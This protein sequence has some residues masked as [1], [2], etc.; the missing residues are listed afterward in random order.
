MLT[1]APLPYAVKPGDEVRELFECDFFAGLMPALLA[2]S[3][4]G[5]VLDLGC[6]DG[7]VGR[8]AGPS[9]QRYVGVDLDPGD[10]PGDA[11]RHDL[12]E[13][14]GPVGSKPFDL[15]VG[16]FGVA[17][18]LAPGE[19]ERLLVEIARHARPG[20]IVALEGLGVNSLEWPRLWNT[21]PGAARL[22][23]YRLGAD[24]TVHPWAPHELAA[25]YESAGIRPLRA[26]DRTVQGAPKTG[27]PRYWPGM[28]CIRRAI[29]ALL[30]GERLHAARAALAAPLPPL[31]PGAP[32]TVHSRIAA[33]RRRAVARG[34]CLPQGLARRV[35]SLDGH[36]SGG[37][38]HG[39]LMVGRVS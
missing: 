4:G 29:A 6:A 13:G 33:R 35:W 38:G 3:S 1:E 5:A 16:T 32:A 28:P 23:P 22:I 15:Y 12:R 19:L 36:R 17:S 31:P 24:V 14:L 11:V 27:D 9:L 39:L 10:L 34:G 2:R 20:A 25:R 18:H 7:L 26:L 8:V 37:F 30:R 21:S